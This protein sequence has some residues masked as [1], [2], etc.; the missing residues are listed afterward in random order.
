MDPHFCD[1]LQ[2]YLD[3]TIIVT[4]LFYLIIPPCSDLMW[5]HDSQGRVRAEGKPQ[6][7]GEG[8]GGEVVGEKKVEVEMREEK[9]QFTR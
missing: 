5:R 3:L 8:G 2:S 4:F 7:R 9:T 6:G 1:L